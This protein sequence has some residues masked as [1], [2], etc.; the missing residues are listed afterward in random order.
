MAEDLLVTKQ[1]FEL[2]ELRTVGGATVRDV[3]VGYETYGALNAARD[4]AILVAHYFSGTS[5]AAGR[6]RP[7]DPLPG[8]WDSIIGPGKAVDTD[9]Y[10]VIASDTLVNFNANDPNVVTTGPASLDPATGRPYGLSFPAVAI[11]DFVRVQKALVDSFGIKRLHAVM[12]PSMGGL[13]TF[14]WAASFPDFME[15]IIPVIAAPNFNGWLTGWLSMWTQPIRLDPDWRGGAYYDGAAPRAGLEAAMRI[16]TLHAL[17]S[18]WADTAGG[19]AVAEGGDPADIAS[20]PFA[21][22][23]TLEEAVRARAP[24]ADANHML[25]LA[26][27]NQTYIP[28]AGAGAASV[29][30][31]LG[32]IKAPTL[33]IYAPDDLV[34]LPEWV[35]ATA[36]ALRGQGVAVETAQLAG[37]YGHYNG[38]MRIADAGPQIAD[39]LARRI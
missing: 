20:T 21:I 10:F 6:Y 33:L 11:A 24:M 5:H 14:E 2:P 1:R 27:A 34:F 28:G 8:Y 29:A 26:R 25:Y 36:K 4:N 35:E 31:G 39:F 17:H 16:M 12:G 13:Q 19:R 18:E 7:D 23:K 37:P 22:D 38:I 32:R 9:R 30:E 15:R 3:A